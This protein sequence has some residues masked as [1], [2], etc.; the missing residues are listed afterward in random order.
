MEIYIKEKY[1]IK[2][3]YKIDII[4]KL[5]FHLLYNLSFL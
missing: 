5:Q 1:T 4:I 3:L 2:K